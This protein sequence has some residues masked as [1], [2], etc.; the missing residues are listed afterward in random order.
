VNHKYTP[1]EEDR[2]K[3]IESLDYLPQNSKVYKMHVEKEGSHTVEWDRW[4]M[5]ALIG[6]SIGL[7]G[8]V[9]HQLI[10]TINHARFTSAYKNVYLT[11]GS[12]LEIW[13]HLTAFSLVFVVFAASI[14][15]YWHPPAAGSGIP[16]VIAFL[17]GSMLP[18]VFNVKT[19]VTKV[20]SCAAAVG[21]GL[22][23]GPE[24]PMIH[25]GAMIGAGLS[26]MRSS[27][28]GFSLPFFTRFRNA[29]DRRDFISAGA[30]AGV[31]AAFG[32]PVGGLLFTMEE[33]SSFWD[34]KLGWQIF[35]CCMT[36]TFTTSLFNSAFAEEGFEWNG[37]FGTLAGTS[38]ILFEIKAFVQVD[39]L[40]FLPAVICGITGGALGTLFTFCNLKIS[41]W[42]GRVIAK[43]KW[44]RVL[45]PCVIMMLYTIAIVYIPPMHSCTTSSCATNPDFYLDR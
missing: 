30:G 25:M 14:T 2:L 22:P 7:V 32:A 19:L 31:S 24:G 18:Q 27:T 16:E 35:F 40:I 37:E 17:N 45:E 38:Q 44:A 43:R 36:S 13:L 28:L 23:V 5:M 21:A 20:L 8:F 26:Q 9:L 1:E 34:Q 12:H 11:G 42:R 4:V 39:I 15:A 41:R 29:K 3:H 6:F 33:V 10:A